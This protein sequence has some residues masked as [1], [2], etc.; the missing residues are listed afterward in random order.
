M[1]RSVAAL[2]CAAATSASAVPLTCAED[3]RTNGLF[4]FAPTELREAAGIRNAPL[5]TGGPNEINKTAFTIAANCGSGVMHLKDK[6]GVSF[7]GSG[8]SDGTP[9]S[10]ELNRLFCKA[11]MPAAS[12][13][14]R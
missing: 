7:A 4:C 8:P 1:R 11:A 9:Q 2:L 12:V 5:Y 10:R 13:Q 3:K 6:R 14:K